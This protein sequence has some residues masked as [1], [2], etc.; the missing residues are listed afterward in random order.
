MIGTQLPWIESI[1]LEK[2][3]NHV[4]TLEY[5]SIHNHHPN[6]TVLHPDKLRD[7]YIKGTFDD[8]SQMFDA[9]VTFSSLEHSGLGR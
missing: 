5:T 3:A 1:L 8:S 9:V 4:T 2:W 6:I 7:M